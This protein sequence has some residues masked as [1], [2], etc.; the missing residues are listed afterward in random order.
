[1]LSS[2][3][4][5][6]SPFAV[7]GPC[8]DE[9]AVSRRVDDS[10]RQGDI[11]SPP[12]ESHPTRR[13]SS[14][15]GEEH[16]GGREVHGGDR[17]RGGKRYAVRV[18]C[19]IL[20]LATSS[21]PRILPKPNGNRT[22]KEILFSVL[23]RQKRRS[24][25]NRSRPGTGTGRPFKPYEIRTSVGLAAR[26]RC[27]RRPLRATMVKRVAATCGRRAEHGLDDRDAGL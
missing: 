12:A 20:P 22:G 17:E 21:R 15:E 3:S 25:A 11:A 16:D 18:L 1:M 26:R 10:A 2:P 5:L 23:D 7:P 27:R 14:G 24:V 8:T 19:T 4:L 13:T 6:E 9:H